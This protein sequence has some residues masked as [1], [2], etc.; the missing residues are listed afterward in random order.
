MF[1]MIQCGERPRASRAKRARRSASALKWARQELERHLAAQL[2]VT[3]PVN[4]PHATFAEGRQDA[5]RAE[6]ASH[7]V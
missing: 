1:G 6:V 3:R 2:G 7:S 5:I 4:F